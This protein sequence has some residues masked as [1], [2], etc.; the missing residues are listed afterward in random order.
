MALDMLL[1]DA[2]EVDFDGA[3]SLERCDENPALMERLEEPDEEEL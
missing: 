1:D 3:A 2:V